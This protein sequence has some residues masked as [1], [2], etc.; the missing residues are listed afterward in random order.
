MIRFVLERVYAALDAK[1][2]RESSIEEWADAA[3]LDVA[4]SLH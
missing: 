4:A 2:V 3:A 1:V